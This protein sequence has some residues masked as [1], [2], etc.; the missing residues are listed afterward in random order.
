MAAPYWLTAR[1]IA[2]RGL[3]DR[4]KGVIENTCG[5]A[6]AAIARGYAIVHLDDG[7]ILSDAADAPVGTALTVAVDRGSLRAVSEG[8]TPEAG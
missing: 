7:R 8:E 1:P 2:H 4:A 3:H 6:R 5:A